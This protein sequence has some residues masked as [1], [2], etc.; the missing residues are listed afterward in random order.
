V[1][2]RSVRWLR[3]ALASGLLAVAALG[4]AAPVRAEGPT[5]EA[6]AR[7]RE[8]YRRG[9]ALE[10]AGDWEGAL[11]IFKGVALV[12]STPQVRFHIAQCEEKVGNWV[13]ALGSYR[14]ALSEA[15]QGNVA[16]V[17]K[18]AAAAI[19]ALE[20]RVPRLTIQRGTGAAAARVLLDGRE[21]G[22][23]SVGTPIAV[24]PGPHRIEASSPGRET[25]VTEVVAEEGKSAEVALTLKDQPGAAKPQAPPAEEEGGSALVPVGVVTLGVGVA[26]LGASG[27]FFAMRGSA[28]SDLDAA[29]G[30]DGRSC[31]SDL[32]DTADSG[33]TYATV[34]TV[35]FV[36]GLTCVA[37]GTTLLVVG[38]GSEPDSAAATSAPR[39]RAAFGPGSMS[40][41][42]A[43]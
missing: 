36:A 12:K 23:A 19:E 8:E 29:C 9:L 32:Q 42:G 26:S 6:L 41:T 30:P 17:Q 37:L 15:Q 7:A 5:P 27:I 28:I 16:E 35:T 4:V 34:S 38:L 40:V 25:A 33:A 2:A 13:E 24:N 1:S 21:L 3:A 31:P 14:L 11:V 39:A 18:E 22:P 43:F 10:Q 20:P